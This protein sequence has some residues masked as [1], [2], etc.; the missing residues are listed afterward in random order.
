MRTKLVL[1]SVLLSSLAS[2][3]V[4]ILLIVWHV[5]DTS[6]L[7]RRARENARSA[8]IEIERDII[9]FV[10]KNLLPLFFII[11]VS[12][13]LFYLH[14]NELGTHWRELSP[15]SPAGRKAITQSGSGP[16]FNLAEGF[17]KASRPLT[18]NRNSQ[19]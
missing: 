7:A 2:L 8:A 6:E 11:S 16:I 14:R 12:H 4:L 1:V 5:K 13:L 19:A 3:V 10:M 9:S 18:A 17:R 15:M